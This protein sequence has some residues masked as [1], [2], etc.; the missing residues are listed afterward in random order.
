MA[1]CLWAGDEWMASHSTAAALLGF[2]NIPHP[3]V[4]I[5]GPRRLPPRAPGIV[6][7]TTTNLGP[8]DRA[9]VKPIPVTSAARTLVDLGAIEEAETVE[10]AL[11]AALRKGL[12]SISYLQQRLDRYGRGH[13]GLATIKEVLAN[14]TADPRP[15]GSDFETLLFQVLRR[16]GVPIPVRQFEIYDGT[17]FIARPDFCYPSQK[18]IIEADSYEHHSGRLDWEHDLDRRSKLAVLG[19]RML[20]VTWWALVKT[21]KEVV[22]RVARAL[23][24]DPC[25]FRFE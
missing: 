9:S 15:T 12:T 22:A 16:E 20:N 14:R 4:H 10:L 5:L 19:W 2:V 1:S 7:H 17:E 21:P 11:E 13:R 8:G 6:V 3:T 18:L 25:S 23:G 24:L